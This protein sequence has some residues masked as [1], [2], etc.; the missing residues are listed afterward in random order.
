VDRRVRA[1]QLRRGRLRQ[2]EKLQ[3]E[4]VR[5]GWTHVVGIVE[6]GLMLVI[7]QAAVNLRCLRVWAAR[8][9][10]RTD[11]LTWDDPTGNPSTGPPAA[12]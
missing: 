2:P 3:A 4:S 9:G 6:T 8:T 10:D 7:A 1:P 5:R 11:P 12:T